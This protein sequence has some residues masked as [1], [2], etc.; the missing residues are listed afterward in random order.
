MLTP[1]SREPQPLPAPGI[2]AAP[3]AELPEL[4]GAKIA[5]VGL[6]HKPAEVLQVASRE[7]GIVQHRLARCTIMH[8]LAT[9]LT[10]E[11]DWPY[12]TGL[13]PLTA[14]W[15]RDSDGPLARHPPGT[16]S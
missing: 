14:L 16:A 7:R 2:L 1:P 13:G 5:I 15:I 11:R 10:P 9:G 6:H 12:A 8:L 3:V 4:D